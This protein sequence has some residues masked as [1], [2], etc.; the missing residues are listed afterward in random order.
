M[1]FYPLTIPNFDPMMFG[2]PDA[3]KFSGSA[4]PVYTCVESISLYAC[5]KP[6]SVVSR[7]DFFCC[8]S[9]RYSSVGT[10]LLSPKLDEASTWF[11]L[12]P[13]YLKAL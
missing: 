11:L 12:L 10:R 8:S 9:R 7:N 13:F 2:R 5:R 1:L 6:E 4:S 3:L